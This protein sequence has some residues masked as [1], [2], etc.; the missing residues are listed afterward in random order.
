MTLLLQDVHS[1]NMTKMFKKFLEAIAKA[2]NTLNKLKSVTSLQSI[3]ILGYHISSGIIKPDPERLC[4][5]KKLPPLEN[6]KSAKRAL[7]MFRPVVENTKF[8][9]ETKA[10]KAFKQ[11]K[12]ELEVTTLKPIDES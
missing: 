1:Q 3:N 2:D 8:P 9:L 11:L 12:Q 6:L 4:P 5:L 7:G 10:L